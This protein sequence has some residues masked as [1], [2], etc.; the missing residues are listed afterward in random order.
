[1]MRHVTVAAALLALAGGIGSAQDARAVLQAAAAAMGATGLKTIQYTGAGWIAAVGQSYTAASG[2]WPR[3]EVTTY[4]RTIDYDARSLRDEYVR[5]QGGNPPRGGGGTPLQGEQRIVQILGGG[6]AWNLDAQGMP[7]AQTRPYLDGTPVSDLRQ[8]EI[9]LT[10]HGFLKAAAGAGPRVHS[11]RIMG[12][13][14]DGLTGDGRRVHIVSF[15]ALGRYKVNGTINDKNMVELV[16]TWIPNPVYGDM[17]YEMRYTDYRDFGGVMFPALVHV[18]QG[19]PVLNPAHNLMEIKVAGVTANV[20]VPAAPV[21]DA[22]RKATAAPVRVE[23]QPLAQGVWLLGGGTHH[24]VAVEFRDHVAVIEAPLNEDRS[25]AVIDAVT[26]LVPSKPIRYAVNTHHHFD[27]SGGLRTY[28]SQ[29]STIVT[30]Q[31]NRDF[32]QTV[33]FHPGSRTLQPDRLA[34]F[35]PMYMTSRRP[36][37]IET[38]ADKP[39]VLSDGTRTVELHALADLQHAQHMLV[40]WLPKERILVNADLYSPPAAGAAPPAPTPAMKTLAENIRR[41]KLDVAQH[42]GIHGQVGTHEAFLKIVGGP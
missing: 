31:G 17:L 4:T 37:R 14:N 1:M 28:L 12:P 8:L 23:P 39:H 41:L 21:P 24:S 33:L 13:S 11:M 30:H 32:H 40:A 5:R 20:S 35:Y 26:G 15:T 25:L 7:V 18:H 2:D 16:T 22:I 34:L 3:F 6:F 10:P 27:H 19:D 36:L 38:V 29:G 42:V 9:L